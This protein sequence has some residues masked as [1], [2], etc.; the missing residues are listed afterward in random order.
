LKGHATAL[1]EAKRLKI[2]V[3]A[4]IDSD[5]NPEA[6]DYPIPAN[7]HAKSSIDWIVNQLIEKLK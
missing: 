4:V 2:P 5:D 6:V 1:R 3:V 7:D